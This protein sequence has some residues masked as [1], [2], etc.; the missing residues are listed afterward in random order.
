MS[1]KLYSVDEAQRLAKLKL[2]KMIYDFVEGAA[3]DES[4][5]DL[6]TAALD[7]IRLMPR[8]LIDVSKRRL[9]HQFLDKDFGLPFKIS[10]VNAPLP[11]PTSITCLFLILTI[12]IIFFITFLSIRKFCPSDFFANFILCSFL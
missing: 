2:P 1:Q 5:R 10:S 9:D 8:V 7:K 3:G 12:L 4:L 11:G 6:N